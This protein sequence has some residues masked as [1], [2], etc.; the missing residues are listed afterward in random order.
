MKPMEHWD[1]EKFSSFCNLSFEWVIS[2]F[3]KK[4]KK[5]KSFRDAYN[6]GKQ[7]FYLCFEGFLKNCQQLLYILGHTKTFITSLFVMNYNGVHQSLK[8][9]FGAHVVKTKLGTSF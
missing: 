5:L 4:I 7:N 1:R 8:S 2:F 9:D 3:P 6:I